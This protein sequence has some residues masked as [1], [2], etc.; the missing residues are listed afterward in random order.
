MYG[1]NG[2]KEIRCVD[3]PAGK[4]LGDTGKERGKVPCELHQS[5]E[6]GRFAI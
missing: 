6:R 3:C 4:E 5:E 2:G 1:G